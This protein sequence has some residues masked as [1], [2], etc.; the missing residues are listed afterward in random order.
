[1]RIGAQVTDILGVHSELNH[2]IQ[3]YFGQEQN[4]L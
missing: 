2:D 3:S 1:M 4:Y